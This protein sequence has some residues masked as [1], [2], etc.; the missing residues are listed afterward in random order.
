MNMTRAALPQMRL[1]RSGRI[2]SISWVGRRIGLIRAHAG[3]E[4]GDPEKIARLIVALAQ[5]DGLLAYLVRGTDALSSF[6]EAEAKNS[7][8]HER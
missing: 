5:R 7:R 4:V 6:D 8:E 1:H 3:N 2:F